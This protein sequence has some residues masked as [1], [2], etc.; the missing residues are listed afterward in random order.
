MVPMIEEVPAGLRESLDSILEESFTG[1]YLWHAKKTLREIELVQRAVLDG[2]AAGLSML[3]H[4]PRGIGYIYYIAVARSK[5]RIG[6]GG[7]LLDAAVE[8]FRV[9]GS[10]EVLASARKDNAGSVGLILSRGF[11]KTDFKAL[12][13]EHG[14]LW[15]ARLWKEMLVVPGEI[16]FR[17]RLAV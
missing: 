7:T 2:E 17:K 5:R 10:R 16:A 1:I 12:S 14:K 13:E 9:S 11:E 15:A 8:V 6:I 4:L 3:E